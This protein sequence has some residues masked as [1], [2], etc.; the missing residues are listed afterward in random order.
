MTR[1]V[2]LLRGVNVGKAKRVAMADLRSLLES[3]GYGGVRTLLN[4]GN[5]VFD[6]PTESPAN[7][8][9]RIQA[10]MVRELGVEALV[11]VR[12]AKDMA[13]VVAGNKL[14]AL[15]T[16]PSRLL[17]AVASDPKALAALQLPAR[18]EWGSDEVHV[19]KH[20]AY[21]W[22]ANGILESKVAV[23]LLKGLARSGTTRN[24]STVEKLHALLQR[25]I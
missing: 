16:D 19:G 3:L 23:A 22:C 7:H 8:A 2:T 15:A 4:S 18:A 25:A 5:A 10:A 12:S 17:V 1:F 20:A 6:G 9:Q 24:W 14:A 11:I 13:A 21:V